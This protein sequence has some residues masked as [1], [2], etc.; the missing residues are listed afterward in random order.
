MP[1]K[2]AR[3]SFVDLGHDWY[4]CE[5]CGKEYKHTKH[6]SRHLGLPSHLS[7]VRRVEGDPNGSG[8]HPIPDIVT[9]AGCSFSVPVAAT[10]NPVPVVNSP[11]RAEPS[12]SDAIP[13]AA[14]PDLHTCVDSIPVDEDEDIWL[15]PPASVT[16]AVDLPEE[17]E[18]QGPFTWEVEESGDGAADWSSTAEADVP[19][20]IVYAVNLLLF[21]HYSEMYWWMIRQDWAPVVVRCNIRFLVQSIDDLILYAESEWRT[22]GGIGVESVL[23]AAADAGLY[24]APDLSRQV[25]NAELAFRMDLQ[26]REQQNK[27]KPDPRP[28][29]V[30]WYQDKADE[31]VAVGTDVTIRQACF[32]LAALKLRGGMTGQCMD[33]IC[34]LLSMGGLL[35]EDCNQ[36]PRCD[37]YYISCVRHAC[38]SSGCS[39]VTWSLFQGRAVGIECP[40]CRSQHLVNGVLCLQKADDY[41]W[42]MC[43]NGQCATVYGRQLP[44]ADRV[45]RQGQR[46]E[47]CGNF[48]YV[49]RGNQLN[50][51]R[52]CVH[53]CFSSG[54]LSLTKW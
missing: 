11:Q 39:Y 43:D 10:E 14:T 37:T 32:C 7:N 36:M 6:L 31:K 8:K 48:R 22:R 49:K 44:A 21:S 23:R 50:A 29:T 1:E 38:C 5:Y 41:A 47:R 53:C 17:D 40:C 30:R 19:S 9:P 25:L 24:G 4:F 12:T 35:P 42:D 16:V 3:D 15:L 18:H 52:R 20:E 54:L 33:D 34:R 45:K 28:H 27:E 26:F 51:A 46:C 13:G 2:R